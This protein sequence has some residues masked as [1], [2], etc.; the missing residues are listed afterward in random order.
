MNDDLPQQRLPRRAE[1]D[2]VHRPPC[3]IGQLAHQNNLIFDAELR[4][5]I[6]RKIQIAIR[7][8]SA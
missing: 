1:V 6:D 7:P 2:Q 8:L 3:R 4:T 5:C